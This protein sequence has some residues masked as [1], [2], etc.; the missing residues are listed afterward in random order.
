MRTGLP[1]C[2]VSS[3]QKHIFPN[4]SG[5]LFFILMDDSEPLRRL[6]MELFVLKEADSSACVF[7]GLAGKSTTCMFI[8]GTFWRVRFP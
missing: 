2:S 5:F 4:L 1:Q 7:L 6:S 3:T 8:N